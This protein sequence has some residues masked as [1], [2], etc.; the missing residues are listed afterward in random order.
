V[1]RASGE[2]A[3]AFPRQGFTLI[4]LLVVIAII[5]LLAS[6][7][8]PA[9]AKAKEAA[10]R[11]QCINHLKQL[12]LCLRM[13]ADENEGF[14]PP[15]SHPTLADTNAV[16]WCDRIYKD[17][18]DLKLLVCPNDNDPLSYTDSL[19]QRYPAS[20]APR[21]YIMNGFNDYYTSQF[22]TNV[23]PGVGVNRAMP[24]SAITEPSDTILLG[25]KMEDKQDM[26]FDFPR[27]MDLGNLDQSKHSTGAG[28]RGTGGSNHAFADG[29]ARF[30]K[31]GQAF[32]P[33]NMWA[34][35]E[36]MRYR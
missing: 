22:N 21:S 16:R 19:T 8:L 26:Y 31:F 4:E 36:E 20:F 35:T 23:V 11:I 5:A 2:R 32:D 13:Y 14:L 12:G 30:L 27:D 3:R 24:E 18:V 17:F 33:V 28:K 1:E 9:L 25:E 6:M 10:R 29:S 15:R 34:I 7:L